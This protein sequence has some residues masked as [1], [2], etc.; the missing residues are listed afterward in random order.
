MVAGAV[1]G[2][3][4]ACGC[5]WISRKAAPA[6]RGSGDTH[7][8]ALRDDVTQ[9]KVFDFSGGLTA[10]GV[11]LTPL[12]GVDRIDYI[13]YLVIRADPQVV[14]GHNGVFTGPF[15][16]F[17]VPYMVFVESKKHLWHDDTQTPTEPAKTG[18]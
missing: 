3:I 17:L 2:A 18:P 5:P 11:R 15:V 6:E 9:L 14:D 16:D 7:V 12:G 13:P 1:P 10:G 8:P 4:G